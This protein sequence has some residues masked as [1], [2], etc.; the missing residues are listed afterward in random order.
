MWLRFIWQIFGW[1][2]SLLLI[3]NLSNVSTGEYVISDY[4]PI[5]Y[6]VLFASKTIFYLMAWYKLLIHGKGLKIRSRIAQL[7]LLAIPSVLFAIY[8]AYP[9]SFNSLYSP[10]NFLII[11]MHI[12]L[13]CKEGMNLDLFPFSTIFQYVLSLMM[14]TDIVIILFE[15]ANEYDNSVSFSNQSNIFYGYAVILF[16]CFILISSICFRCITMCW[17]YNEFQMN[18]IKNEYINYINQNNNINLLNS[19]NVI[20]MID[21]NDAIMPMHVPTKCDKCY[22]VI[23]SIL[24][25]V[26]IHV[27]VMA[28]IAFGEMGDFMSHTLIDG[29]YTEL[30][31]RDTWLDNEQFQMALIIDVLLVIPTITLSIMFI[32]F[33]ITKIFKI[34]FCCFISSKNITF[35]LVSGNYINVYSVRIS[36]ANHP[37]KIY[38]HRIWQY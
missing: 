33:I 20:K 9:S 38:Q 29:D 30:L 25:I 19:K 18:T 15:T 21:D 2:S 37:I 6:I 4:I 13:V 22:Y 1:I 8:L 28:I 31:N 14:G 32:I 11:V 5:I 3:L 10:D 26:F 24:F 23:L 7:W 35:C 12:S 34:L 27:P 36:T 17:E 16:C